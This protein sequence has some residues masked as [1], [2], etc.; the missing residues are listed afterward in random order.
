MRLLIRYFFK[1]L[2]AILGPLMLLWEWLTPPKGIKRPESEQQQVDA[3]TRNLTLY[4]FLTCPFCIRVR[5]VIKRLSLNIETRDALK[6]PVSRQQLLEGG[7]TIKVPCLKI[8]DEQGE[9]RWLYESDE[10]IRH[11]EANIPDAES[12]AHPPASTPGV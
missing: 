6:D 7:G 11:L 1:L 9:T 10:I 4:Q 12:P 3:Y 5:R 8:A 2:R